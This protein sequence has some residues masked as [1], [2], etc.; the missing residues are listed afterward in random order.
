MIKVDTS[1]DKFK[2]ILL[3]IFPIVPQSPSGGYG[4]P[5]LSQTITNLMTLLLYGAIPLAVLV[6]LYGG[7]TILTSGG[8]ESRYEKGKDAI[9]RAVIGLFIVFGS[10]ILV[11]LVT[12]ALS[13]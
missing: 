10:Y 13:G 5:E 1:R 4:W 6:I 9:I 11:S 12:R 7:F 2:G 8:S 3:A